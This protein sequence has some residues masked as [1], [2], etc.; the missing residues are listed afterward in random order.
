V[1]ELARLLRRLMTGPEDRRTAHGAAECRRQEARDLLRL[2]LEILHARYRRNEAR[3]RRIR[4]LLRQAP[5]FEARYAKQIRQYLGRSF[6]DRSRIRR[7][8]RRLIDFPKRVEYANGR[9]RWVTLRHRGR[10]R[11]PE[12][13]RLV[14]HG[15]LPVFTIRKLGDR[16][17]SRRVP[18]LVPWARMAEELM[19][20]SRH[21]V[22][23][24]TRTA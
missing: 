21:D 8:A 23:R 7:E 3:V 24:T 16:W 22:E 4:R 19:E 5:G 15:E 2:K 1:L 14:E 18:V 20:I 11:Y 10:V 17:K 12:F 9:P 6:G 13:V